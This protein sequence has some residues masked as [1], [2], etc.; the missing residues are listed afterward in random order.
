VLPDGRLH[1]SNDPYRALV[2]AHD[3]LTSILKPWG[4]AI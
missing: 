4:P 2:G 3:A 1:A